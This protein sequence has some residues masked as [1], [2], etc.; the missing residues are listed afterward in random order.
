M[1]INGH[2]RSVP[3]VAGHTCTSGKTLVSHARTVT[4]SS[5]CYYNLSKKSCYRA[6]MDNTVE[7]FE[8]PALGGDEVVPAQ[9]ASV[10]INTNILLPVCFVNT[11]PSPFRSKLTIVSSKLH[12][13]HIVDIAYQMT[14]TRSAAST[15]TKC[16]A[17]DRK[18]AKEPEGTCSNSCVKGPGLRSNVRSMWTHHVLLVQPML[19]GWFGMQRGARQRGRPER[20]QRRG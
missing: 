10:F 4:N 11:R 3:D 15:I 9:Q 6:A 8:P 19:Q 7:S 13:K 5:P 20:G 1:T 2:A 16:A 12:L 14:C 18:S 17:R